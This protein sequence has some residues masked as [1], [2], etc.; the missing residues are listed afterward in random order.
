MMYRVQLAPSAVR[1][2]DRLSPRYVHAVIDFIYGPLAQNPRRVGKPLGGNLLG[3]YSA[4]RGAYR[5]IYELPDDATVLVIRVDHRAH[6][7]RQR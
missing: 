4:R 1:S 3:F 5:V 2:L 7:Y 6:V